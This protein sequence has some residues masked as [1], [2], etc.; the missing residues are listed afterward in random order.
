MKKKLAIE[1]KKLRLSRETL[2][3]LKQR[4]LPVI[5]GGFTDPKC[6][7]SRCAPTCPTC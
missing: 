3:A 2:R 6:S 1:N 4:D 5:V 7:V